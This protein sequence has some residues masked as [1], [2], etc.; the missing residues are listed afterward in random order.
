[1]RECSLAKKKERKKERERKERIIIRGTQIDQLSLMLM[2]ERES[3]AKPMFPML[4]LLSE[5]GQ[6]FFPC[7]SWFYR[8]EFDLG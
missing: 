7:P 4:P 5:T 8:Q 6:L 3:Y 1:M 2:H